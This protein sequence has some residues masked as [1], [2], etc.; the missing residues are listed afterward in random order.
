MPASRNVDLFLP[1]ALR[2]HLGLPDNAR[3]YAR[4]AYTLAV[5]SATRARIDWIVGRRTAEDDPLIPSRLLFATDGPTAARRALRLFRP[6]PS[7]HELPPL[8]GG[9]PAPGPARNS[10]FPAPSR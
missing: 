2:A 8:A 7:R 6:A 1:N 4:D 3:R 5:A 10:S 9:W